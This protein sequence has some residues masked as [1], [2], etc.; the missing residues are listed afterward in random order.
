M[1]MVGWGV[2]KARMAVKPVEGVSNG[3]TFAWSIGKPLDRF[4][5]GVSPA[6]LAG[7]KSREKGVL[8]APCDST[9]FAEGDA[10]GSSRSD[11]EATRGVHEHA[12]APRVICGQTLSS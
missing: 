6:T 12:R 9:T 10:G 3:D 5:F 1:R 2:L 4:H 11:R 7:A 8:P